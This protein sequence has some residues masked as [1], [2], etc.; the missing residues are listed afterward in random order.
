M[1]ENLSKAGRSFST[2]SQTTKVHKLAHKL[3]IR[4]KFR[5]FKDQISA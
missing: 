4:I 5:V 2:S 3:A 1:I